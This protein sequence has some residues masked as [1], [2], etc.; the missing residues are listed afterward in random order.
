MLTISIQGLKDGNTDISLSAQAS[1][2][3]YI[4]PEFIGE[5]SLSGVLTKFGKRYS[6][7]G[8]ATCNAL[9]VCDRTLVEYTEVISAPITVSY[10]ADTQV[11]L[12]QEDTSENVYVIREDESFIDLTDDV[13]EELA[14][15]LP[16]KRISPQFRDKE[17][18]DSSTETNIDINK[19]QTVDE[20]WS[21]L[22]NIHLNN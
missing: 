11:F 17:R 16:M 4:F 14:L 22:K 13:R 9:L 10:L 5:I 15:H 3:P 1:E 21:T 7:K 2:I 19:E 6:F 20:R 18:E 8:S 12:L